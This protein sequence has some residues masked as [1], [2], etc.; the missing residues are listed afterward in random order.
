MKNSSLFQ[1]SVIHML[2]GFGAQSLFI[3]TFKEGTQILSE[4]VVLA[5]CHVGRST[6]LSQI[7]CLLPP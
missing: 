6:Y 1:K 7:L 2:R 5:S 4:S 3:F